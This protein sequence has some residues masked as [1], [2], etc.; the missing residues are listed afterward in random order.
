VEKLQTALNESQEKLEKVQEQ[1]KH[2]EI[3]LKAI[4]QVGQR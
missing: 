1:S 2:D 3:T 4:L